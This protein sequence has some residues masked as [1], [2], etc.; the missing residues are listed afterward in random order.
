MPGSA[1]AAGQLD[2]SEA[3]IQFLIGAAGGITGRLTAIYAVTL[4]GRQ[5]TLMYTICVVITF[6]LGVYYYE[7]SANDKS[8]DFTSLCS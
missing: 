2:Y 7:L 3:S 4:F 8:W 6:S 5:S 1:A